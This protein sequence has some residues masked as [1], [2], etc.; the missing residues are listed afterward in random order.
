LA[1]ALQ[2]YFQLT[3]NAIASSNE[4]AVAKMSAGSTSSNVE[5]S[6]QGI[7]SGRKQLDYEHSIGANVS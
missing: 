1:T 4:L 2:E 6:S 5:R 7:T 3:D